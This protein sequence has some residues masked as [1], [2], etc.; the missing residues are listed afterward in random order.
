MDPAPN[1]FKKKRVQE[2]PR[3]QKKNPTVLV[4]TFLK[5][6]ESKRIEGF[7]KRIEQ[8]KSHLFS[9]KKNPRKFKVSKKESNNFHNFF[10]EKRIQENSRFQKKNQ[11]I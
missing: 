2:N 1:F 5:K 10:Q 4:S 6:K 7:E 9:G 11:T 3:F 8:F